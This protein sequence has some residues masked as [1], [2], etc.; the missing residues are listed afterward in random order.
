MA[1]LYSFPYKIT[2]ATVTIVIVLTLLRY[3]F[4]YVL[5]CGSFPHLAKTSKDWLVVVAD[6]WKGTCWPITYYSHSMRI[7]SNAKMIPDECEW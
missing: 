2:A 7:T 5:Y 4:A 1:D 6:L 3:C